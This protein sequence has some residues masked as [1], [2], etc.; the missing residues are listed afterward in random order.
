MQNLTVRKKVI[1][2]PATGNGTPTV[3]HYDEAATLVLNKVAEA[4]AAIPFLLTPNPAARAFLRTHKSVP[5]KFIETIAQE[6]GARQQVH[7]LQTIDVDAATHAVQY[8]AAFARVQRVF[9]ELGR[10]MEFSIDSM[11]ANV[12]ADAL[13]AYAVLKALAETAGNEDLVD[14]VV[15]LK[16]ELG[17]VRPKR[18]EKP[19]PEPPAAEEPAGKEVKKAA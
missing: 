2:D 19:Q 18:R 13:D 3:T 10:A 4:V 17:R 15:K 7:A 11:I 6:V 8:A 16:R 12:G 14:V 5:P 9:T 1:P